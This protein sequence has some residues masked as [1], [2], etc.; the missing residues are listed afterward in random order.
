MKEINLVVTD[1]IQ[2]KPTYKLKR[3]DCYG[4]TL[5]SFEEGDKIFVGTVEYKENGE[6]FPVIINHCCIIRHGEICDSAD[7][8]SRSIAAIDCSDDRELFYDGYVVS[9][10]EVEKSLTT[11][12]SSYFEKKYRFL[13]NYLIRK[14]AYTGE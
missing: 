7:G 8:Y 3:Y 11:I 9:K 6:L 13:R 2:L 12:P 1:V 5:N 4:R 14:N 10:Q